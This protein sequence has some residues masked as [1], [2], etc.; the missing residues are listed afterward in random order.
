MTSF[1]LKNTI[2][3]ILR[4]AADKVESLGSSPFK[5]QVYIII[6]DLFHAMCYLKDLYEGN[7]K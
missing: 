1:Q 7:H 2:A 5:A 3:S 6:E 4:D